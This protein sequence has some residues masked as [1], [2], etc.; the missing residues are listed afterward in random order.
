M[1]RF[2][3]PSGIDMERSY[4][5]ELLRPEHIREVARIEQTCFFEPW[6][7]KSLSLL[8][9]G[10]NFGVVALLDGDVAAYGGMTCVLDEGAV[11]NIATLPEYRRLGLGRAV[12]E[13]MLDEAQKRG[14]AVVFLEVRASNEAARGL[15]LSEGFE[16]CGVRKGFYRHP[17]E[18]AVQMV[19][20]KNK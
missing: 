18:D 1:I 12:L 20:Q 4:S 17:T 15:Y 11:T 6:S 10:E 2:R 19:Y 8:T 13:K 16:E 7:E 14:I 3:V 9:E 5:I